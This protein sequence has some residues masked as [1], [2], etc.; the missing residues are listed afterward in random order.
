M[1]QEINYVDLSTPEQYQMAQQWVQAR[2]PEWGHLTEEQFRQNYNAMARTVIDCD[3]QF[4][5]DNPDQSFRNLDAAYSVNKLNGQLAEP[6][7][8]TIHAADDAAEN[9]FIATGK[10]SDVNTYL[11]NKYALEKKPNILMEV[12]GR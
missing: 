12:V 10:L 5:P 2:H 7:P 9:H 8:E 11:Q 3:W 6:S 1:A 4:G